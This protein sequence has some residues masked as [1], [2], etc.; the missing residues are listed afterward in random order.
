MKLMIKILLMPRLIINKFF[1]NKKAN[2]ANKKQTNNSLNKD[3]RNKYGF[4]SCK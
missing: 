3:E 2:S 1:N 4:P